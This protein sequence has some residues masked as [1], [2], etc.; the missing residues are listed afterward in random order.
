MTAARQTRL[1][2][3]SS[4]LSIGMQRRLRARGGE[5]IRHVQRWPVTSLTALAATAILATGCGEDQE[6]PT[7]AQTAPAPPAAPP[8]GP[9]SVAQARQLDSSERVTV[10]GWLLIN[11]RSWACTP[12]SQPLRGETAPGG[13][14]ACANTPE[15]EIVPPGQQPSTTAATGQT[16][17]CDP[18]LESLPPQC[19]RV[20]LKVE[21]LEV[22]RND[23]NR[24]GLRE[25]DSVIWSDKRIVLSGV[26]ANRVLQDAEWAE[27]PNSPEG[28]E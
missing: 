6:S 2:L 3:H 28:A 4:R 21:G 20:A 1:G 16:L 24:L 10:R 25:R 19:G 17:L 27:D 11:S 18:I 5:A 22:D 13:G 9:L 23:L 15:G 8:Q 12:G 14:P 7:P 26:A